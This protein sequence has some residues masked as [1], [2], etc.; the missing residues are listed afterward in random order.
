[1]K[2]NKSQLPDSVEHFK[3]VLSL[4]CWCISVKPKHDYVTSWKKS[5]ECKTCVRVN[6]TWIRMSLMFVY[7]HCSCDQENRTSY[8]W[9]S[10]PTT[11]RL[12][13]FWRQNFVQFM[14]M[15]KMKYSACQHKAGSSQYHF[16]TYSVYRGIFIAYIMYYQTNYV[17]FV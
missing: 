14:V 17:F 3:F 10:R 8:S 15:H 5:D 12:L 2:N 6:F 7:L 13:H 4:F 9:I 11:W 16:T 1:M